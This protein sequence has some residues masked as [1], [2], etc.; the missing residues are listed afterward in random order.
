MASRT[1]PGPEAL[2][3]WLRFLG[4]EDCRCPMAWRSL[5][6]LYGVSMGHG[7]VRTDT[8]PQCRHHGEDAGRYTD[9]L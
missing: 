3:R 2:A 4:T 1:D 5:G 6:V 9:G 7:W 8:D